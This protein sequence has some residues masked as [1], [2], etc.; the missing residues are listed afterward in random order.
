MESRG[1]P[2]EMPARASRWRSRGGRCELRAWRYE[3][4]GISGPAIPVYFVDADLP[5][6]SDW[7]RALTGQLYGGDNHYRLC[8]EVHPR[9]RR[10][11]DA[12]RA[13]LSPSRQVPHE[14]GSRGPAHHGVAATK[15]SR[16]TTSTRSARRQIEAVRDQCVFTTHTPVP[17]D[18]TSSRWTWLPASWDN[19][20]PVARLQDEF[21]VDVWKR[22]FPT[23]EMPADLRQT[24]SARRAAEHDLPGVEPQSIRQRRRQEAR[25]GVSPDVRGIPHRRHHQRCSRSA[26][27]TTPGVPELFDRHIPG[28]RDR[29]FLVCATRSA[30]RG[31]RSGRRIWRASRN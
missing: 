4:Q 12:A 7:D 23:D 3:V 2:E 11:A 19:G 25:R 20:S 21:C 29:Q 22:T 8:Q 5:E 18:T 6:N 30:S 31:G 15:R 10:R 24:A 26:R 16:P 9:H 1:I 28:W 27:G 14:R 13:G 17:P